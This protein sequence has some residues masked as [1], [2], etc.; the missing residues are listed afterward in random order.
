M[1]GRAGRREGNARHSPGRAA[2]SAPGAPTGTR[3]MGP[4]TPRPAAG[5]GPL[6]HL[7]ST[8]VA[9]ATLAVL[10]VIMVLSA[11]FFRPLF[12][13]PEM[14]LVEEPLAKDAAFQL[15]PGERYTY[16]MGGNGTRVAVGFQVLAGRNC[17]V[18]AFMNSQPP[19][20]SC[21]RAD[22]MD[23]GGY[24]SQLGNQDIF[25]YAP[26]MLSLREGWRW[27]VSMYLSY[28]GTLAYIASKDYRV[29]R[30]EDYR[31]RR[32]FVVA[33]NITGSAPQYDWVDAEKRI[34]LRLQGE[35]YAIELVEGLNLTG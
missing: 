29:V 20:T 6:A 33:E 34:L 21:V 8:Q 13:N 10:V 22:G 32:A 26:W 7:S 28:N 12:E 9:I 14:V 19:S 15:K 31:G 11:L 2:G 3:N 23:A 4:G 30:V 5:A 35:G 27:N 18:I 25:M 17:T 16:G 1:A 24:N